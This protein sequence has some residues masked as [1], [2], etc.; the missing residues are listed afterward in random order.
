[1]DVRFS[2]LTVIPQRITIGALPTTR[3]PQRRPKRH[4]ISQRD[5]TRLTSTV[6]YDCSCLSLVNLILLDSI[7]AT[8]PKNRS[9]LKSLAA[10]TFKIDRIILTYRAG[11]KL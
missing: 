6:D 10:F 5:I 4:A 3:L 9:A 11:L 1:M 2:V 8:I 7:S